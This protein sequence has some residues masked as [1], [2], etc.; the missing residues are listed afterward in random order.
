MPKQ[1]LMNKKGNKQF[2]RR[3]GFMKFKRS[4]L[5]DEEGA[6]A[7]F[8]AI[9]M[10]AVL[11]FAAMTIDFGLAYYQKNRLQTACDAAAMGAAQSIVGLTDASAIEQTAEEEAIYYLEKNGFAQD[12]LEEC[13]I[14]VQDY[15]V[16]VKA[17]YKSI[18]TFTNLFKDE[19]GF[20]LGCEAAAG[21]EQLP[22][23][24]GANVPYA[25]YYGSTDGTLNLGGT[26]NIIGTVHSNADVNAAGRGSM[27][28]LEVCGSLTGHDSA[29]VTSAYNTTIKENATVDPIS[30]FAYLGTSIMTAI[31]AKYPTT[32]TVPTDSTWDKV[33]TSTSD[34]ESYYGITG[35][36]YATGTD[37]TTWKLNT[38]SEVNITKEAFSSGNSICFD[39]SGQTTALNIYG[40][41]WHSNYG[42]DIGGSAYF[43]NSAT[44]STGA[45]ITV[46]GDIYCDGDLDISQWG[47][48]VDVNI[49]GNIYCTG[50]LTIQSS[51]NVSIYGDVYAGGAVYLSP[52]SSSELKVNGNVYCASGDIYLGGADTTINGFVY[53]ET[54]SIQCGAS[55]AGSV[56]VS[57]AMV[58]EGD[59]TFQGSMKEVTGSYATTVYSKNGDITFTAGAGTCGTYS[60]IIYCPNG[61][62][63]LN[64]DIYIYGNVIALTAS[65]QPS[66][67]GGSII[68]SSQT[69]YDLG[70]DITGAPNGGSGGSNVTSGKTSLIK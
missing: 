42:V 68:D 7:V 51:A 21:S 64:S 66:D 23:G 22:S 16:T 69:D 31:D 62:V 52:N 24:G 29:Y 47:S 25:L 54:G 56:S 70:Y 61:N 3:D 33:F 26:I 57:G 11:G 58:A 60:G 44:I 36:D 34:L 59:I 28:T 32:I 35:S 37:G 14:E 19:D 20:V 1:L 46:N 27:T 30:N 39:S 5:K 9:C 40:T 8:A 12:E 17:K 4:F 55:Q 65:A 63:T 48:E 15:I 2:I 6:I 45:Y 50:K 10:V 53:A 67:G 49:Y 41:K 18:T 43:L 13:D 38:S